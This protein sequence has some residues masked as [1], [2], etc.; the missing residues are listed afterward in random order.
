VKFFQRLFSFAQ[1]I[2]F[3]LVLWFV[4]ILGLV[5]IAFSL[6]V[7]FN[8]AN[9]L[10]L[11][12]MDY[13]QRRATRLQELLIVGASQARTQGTPQA[14][15]L[16]PPNFLQDDDELLILDSAGTVLASH[17]PLQPQAAATLATLGYHGQ[18][19]PGDAAPATF[20]AWSGQNSPNHTDYLFLVA[21]LSDD[22]GFGGS[23]VLGRPLDAEGQLQ[24]LVFTLLAGSFLTLLVAL[25]GGLWLADRAMRPV[26]TI[27]HTARQISDS[28]LSRRLNMKSKDELGELANTFDAMLSRL[29]A[30]F[31]RQREFVADAS[32]ELRTPLTIVNLEASH[33][34]AARRSPQEYER[35]M[36]VIH[37]END[38]MIRLVN[39]LLALAR[40]DAGQA[41]AEQ[42]PLDLSDIAI[43][44]VERLSPLAARKNVRVEMGDLP[45]AQMRGDRQY[46][47]QMASNLVENAIK[48]S[49][50]ESPA[51]KVETGKGTDTVWLRVS[52]NGPGIA[53][54]HIPHLFERFYRVDQ[55]RSRTTDTAAGES[56]SGSGLGLSIVHWVVKAHTGEIKVISAPGQGTTFEVTFPGA[57]ASP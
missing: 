12:T 5:L 20:I 40:M 21:P 29:Q 2:R 3:R 8:Q 54:E 46:L 31:E 39:D 27:T 38:F 44:I 6:F 42:L 1:S 4:F 53:A 14:V 18:S 47:L 24:R 51:I 35:A 43:D 50:G 9:G 28:D 57:N 23:L 16:I 33:A 36:G 17:G 37:G 30:A 56:A 41:R 32:H 19:H 55:A 15:L 49:S 7:Y 11:A 22:V 52:D 26:K 45:E 10:R 13:L 34:L 48:Y 25:L